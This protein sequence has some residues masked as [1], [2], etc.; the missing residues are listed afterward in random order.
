MQPQMHYATWAEVDLGAIAG[1]VRFFRKTTQRAVMA[2]VKAN[3][4]GHGAAPV[5]RAALEAGASWLAV[6]RAGEALELREAGLAAP[7]LILGYT[8]PARWMELIRA[9]VSLTVWSEAQ[10]A[11]LAAAGRQAGEPAHLHLKVD[12]GMSR[13]GTE[14][15]QA[16][17]LAEK[18]RKLEGVLFEGIF[19]HFARADEADPA[20]TDAQSTRFRKVV[21]ALEHA[22]MRPPWVHASNSAGTL[23]RPE[24]W[25]DLVRVGIAMY[26]LEPSR[27]CPL[28][29]TIRPALAWKSSLAMV[30]TLPPGRGI[31]YGHVYTTTRDERIGTIP[32]GYA[33]G[34]RRIEG[35]V[36]L[37]RGR[38][39]PVIGRVTMDQ[40]MVQLDGV[41]E[42]QVGDVVVLIGRQQEECISA[43]EVAERWGTINYEVTS[44]LAARV[45]RL[46][47]GP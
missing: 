37:V 27:A 34:F 4:Y 45:P 29:E 7:I 32:V 23:R 28:P 9:G 22:G 1:N 17:L 24:A 41:P 20:P 25:Y 40:I 14:P 44:G 16:P 36:V 13:L 33:D 3:A 10:I 5:A 11:E 35:N 39:V 19:T 47:I 12:T 26:G 42:A 2:V 18:I 15:E 30:K 43:E 31:S 38:R 6:A 46:Y 8:S 21:E